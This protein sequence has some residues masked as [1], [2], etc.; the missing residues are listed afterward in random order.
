MIWMKIN[1]VMDMLGFNF[2]HLALMFLSNLWVVRSLE[3]AISINFI[4]VIT[5]NST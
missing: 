1:A 3:A 2:S 4:K 5:T